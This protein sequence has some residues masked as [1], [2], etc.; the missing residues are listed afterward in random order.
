LTQKERLTVPNKPNVVVAFSGG[1]V[2]KKD[3]VAVSAY[4]VGYDD[5]DH[6]IIYIWAD[7]EW[8]HSE[9]D[10]TVRSVEGVE[11]PGR[12]LYCLGID[13]RMSVRRKGGPVEERI[14]DAG[15]GKDKLGYLYRIR[16]I[17]GRLYVCG[18]SGQ[19]YRR[20]KS[21]WVHFDDGVLRPPRGNAPANLYCIDGNS[22]ADIYAVGEKG[23][24][25]HYD[26]KRWTKLDVPTSH[27][28][29]WVRCLSPQEVYLCG[30]GGTVFRGSVNKWEAVSIQNNHKDDLWCAEVYRGKVYFA[31]FKRLFRLEGR[32][33][34][35]LDTNLSPSPD[36]FRLHANDGV[37][38]S[39]GSHHLC[40]FDGKKWTYMKHPE[41]E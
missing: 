1:Y 20:D 5:Y 19:I 17:D 32:N 39:F 26:G 10:F 6:A 4:R 14:L 22:S 36:G 12:M 27:D 34:E 38:W 25:F 16:Q 3:F 11:I 29:N 2:F 33:V 8:T 31:S 21:S 23:L 7:G 37:L 15:T 9:L 24:L 41:N 40:F 18:V 28:L 35:A 30:D 13:G